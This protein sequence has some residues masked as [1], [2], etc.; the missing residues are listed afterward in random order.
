MDISETPDEEMP[1]VPIGA[2]LIALATDAAAK[3]QQF[4]KAWEGLLVKQRIY[5]NKWRECRFNERRTLR[6]LTGSPYRVS[7]STV[8]KWGR[9]RKY[10][11]VR[12]ILQEAS[13]EEILSRNN[14][15]IRQDDI[16]ET[17][18]TPKPILYQGEHTGFEEIDAGAAGRANEVLLKVGG[19]LK[20]KEI[21]L[22]VDI[23][24]PQFTI[25]VVQ[26]DGSVIDATPRGVPVQLPEPEEVIDADWTEI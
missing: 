8:Q 19:H 11:R 26:R 12:K 21:D 5:L 16:V 3:Q 7:K 9:D 13:V 1:A 23:I 15:V 22:S 14:L 2:E 18:L 10:E 6:E 4:V 25:Q 20:D 17:L 24:G